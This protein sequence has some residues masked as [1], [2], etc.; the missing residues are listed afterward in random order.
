MTSALWFGGGA[1]DWAVLVCCRCVWELKLKT[2]STWWK[3]KVSRMMGK[4][5]KYHWPSSNHPSCPLWV[6]IMKNLASWSFLRFQMTFFLLLC[7]LFPTLPGPDEF[8]WVW[9]HASCYLPSPGRF[10]SG[11]H[12]WATFYSWVFTFDKC[13]RANPED[14]YRTRL[15]SRYKIKTGSMLQ[16][17]SSQF[18]L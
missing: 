16:F 12:Q 8:R 3:S 18:S 7:Q 17:H 11:S 15:R 4:V 13:R 10:W 2:I 6:H 14:V 1:A 9:D 5:P